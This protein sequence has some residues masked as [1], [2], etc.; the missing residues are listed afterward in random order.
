MSEELKTVIDNLGSAFEKFKQANDARLEELTKTS[1]KAGEFEGKLANIEAEIKK[2][3]EAKSTLEARLNRPGISEGKYISPEKAEYKE[4]F[5]KFLRKGYESGL[6]ELYL[7]TD[8]ATINLGS[9]DSGGYAVPE[10]LNTTIYQLEKDLSPMRNVCSVMQVGTTNY[11]QLVDLGGTA[12]AWVGETDTRPDT[13][14]PKLAEVKPLFGEVYAQPAATQTA[15]DDMFFDAES[16]LSSSIAEAFAKA[17]NLAFTSGDGTNKPKGLLAQTMATTDDSTRAFGTLQYVKTGVASG[18][19]ATSVATGDL[20]IDV[21]HKLKPGYRTGAIWMLNS[22]TL[23]AI[24]KLKDSEN[25]YL[26]QPGL[27]EGV[28]SKILGYGYVEN[29]DFPG[30]GANA[31][32]IAFGNFKETYVIVDRVGIRVLRDPYTNKPYVRFYTTKRVGGMLLNSEAMKL[33][34]CEA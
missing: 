23:S 9:D 16:W 5:S 15:L 14:A 28:P 24:R 2:L 17:E 22:L 26:W 30:V 34:K 27:T 12:T 18:L 20:L 19:P 13:D 8:P 32:C 31:F 3:T 4:A 10:E 11:R 7:K 29:E 1:G 33:I 6:G 25:N 21:I